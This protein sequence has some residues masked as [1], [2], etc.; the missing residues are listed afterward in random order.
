MQTPITRS[1]LPPIG[2]RI[3][4][5]VFVGITLNAEGTGDIALFLNLDAGDVELAWQPALDWAAAISNADHPAGSYDLPTRKEQ[6]LLFAN[7]AEHFQAEWYWSNAQCSAVYAWF[8]DFGNG[9]TYHGH[10]VNDCRVRAVRRL[11]I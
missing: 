3:G 6:A 4:T 1:T 5:D 9:G 7:A 2:T 8:Q 10:K 11:P